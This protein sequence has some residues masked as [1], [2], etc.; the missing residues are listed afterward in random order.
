MG[1]QKGERADRSALII[2]LRLLTL[3]NDRGRGDHQ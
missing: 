1:R 3:V 2:R